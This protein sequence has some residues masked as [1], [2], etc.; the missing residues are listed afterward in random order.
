MLDVVTA[1]VAPLTFPRRMLVE[2]AGA[3]PLALG[4][5]LV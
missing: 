2:M 1:L 3:A 5:A 4:L